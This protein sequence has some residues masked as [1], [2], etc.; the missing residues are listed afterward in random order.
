LNLLDGKI[1]LVTGASHG[2]GRAIAAAFAGAG[3][4]VIACGRD[5]AALASLTQE[6]DGRCVTMRVDVTVEKDVEAVVDDAV[7]KFGRLDVAV[8]SAGTGGTMSMV[9]N[10]DLAAAEE[11]W[12]TNVIGV[13]ACMKYESRAMR[14]RGAGSIVNISSLSAK[15][16]A[17]AM[18]SYCGSKA[19]VNMMTEVAALELGEFGVRVNAIGPGAIETRMTEW[20]KLPGFEEATVIETPLRRVGQTEDLT[21]LALYLASDASSFVTGQI[22]Y[23]DGGA[24]LM[25]YPD[26]PAL[27]RAIRSKQE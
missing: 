20:L 24:S 1:A 21:G 13:L 23:A 22:F 26:F 17:K 25:R 15:M 16:P 6:T 19:A 8:N 3:A 11:I 9:R 5:E 4:N 12:R 10:A 18:A 7:S 2:I 14:Q 27:F